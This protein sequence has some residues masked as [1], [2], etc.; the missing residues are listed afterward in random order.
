MKRRAWHILAFALL[1]AGLAGC[2]KAPDGVI[3]ESKMEEVMVDVAKAEAYISLHPSTFDTDS[4][5][6][7]LKQSVLAKHDLTVSDYDKSLDWYAHHLEI[8]TKVL[9]K[10]GNRLTDEAKSNEKKRHAT[11]TGSDINQ[12]AQARKYYPDHGDTA[13]IWKERRTWMLTGALGEGHIAFDT[14]PDMES[15]RGDAYRL[16][17]KTLRGGSRINLFVAVDYSDGATSFTT[18]TVL[19]EGWTNY[20]VQSDTTRTVKR[21]YGYIHYD[22]KPTQ[23]AFIDSVQLLRTRLDRVRYN[24]FK[25]QRIFD[26]QG[27]SKA[28]I[29]GP[30]FKPKPGLNK[31][32]QPSRPPIVNPNG[33]HL[34]GSDRRKH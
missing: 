19:N 22:M 9:E 30:S 11:P 1:A 8:Y 6:M 27:N 33:A 13:D 34:T 26:P 4:A 7:A 10:A 24:N 14:R 32:S 16:V 21:V 25:L 31:S 15:L 18:A 20:S 2:D 29:E 28:T 5:R 3:K 17:L 12:L 23:V